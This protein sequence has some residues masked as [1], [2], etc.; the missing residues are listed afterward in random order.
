MNGT[1]AAIVHRPSDDLK[2]APCNAACLRA[3]VRAVHK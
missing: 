1:V 2:V 3:A